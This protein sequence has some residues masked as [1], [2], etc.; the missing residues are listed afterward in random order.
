MGSSQ[1]THKFT[2]VNDSIDNIVRIS[3]DVAKRLYQ[4]HVEYSNKANEPNNIVPGHV[5]TTK[6]QNDEVYYPLYTLTALEVLQ[7][8]QIQL[9]NQETYWI[10]RLNE[11]KKN[12]EMID[13][14]LVNEFKKA[15]NIFEYKMAKIKN[16]SQMCLKYEE[17][18]KDC[19]SKNQNKILNCSV[20]LTN[21]AKCVN[22]CREKVMPIQ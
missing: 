14:Q 19:Y 12:H 5:P 9:E 22:E 2:I 11:L 15:K 3:D 18:L 21:Y 6:L 8:N 1:S 13:N 17:S 20:E 4:N 16:S 7:Q 10:N